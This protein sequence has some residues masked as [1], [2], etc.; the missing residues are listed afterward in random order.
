M[1]LPTS[2]DQKKQ[3]ILKKSVIIDNDIIT[4][5]STIG[6]WRSTLRWISHKPKFHDGSCDHAQLLNYITVA[7]IV[8]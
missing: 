8:D 5:H 4:S 1:G 2:D 7:S 3:D 6:L